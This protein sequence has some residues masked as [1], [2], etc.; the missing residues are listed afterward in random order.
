MVDRDGNPVTRLPGVGEQLDT[1]D[2][3][4]RPVR[5]V[6][7]RSG[8]V[9]IHLDDGAVAELDATTAA[10]VGAFLAGHF[11]VV[12]DTARRVAEAGALLHFDWVRLEPGDFAVDATI[13]ELGVRRRT[14]I[15]IVAILRR[16]AP[17]VDPDPDVALRAGDDLVIACRPDDR[18][19]FVRFV[20]E[21]R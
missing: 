9:E 7:Q 3:D 4:G 6:R 12:G 17:L 8:V 5:V 19:A 2:R 18:D 13:A 20:R 14:G 10:A 16:P 1:V 21:G 15:S 11:A